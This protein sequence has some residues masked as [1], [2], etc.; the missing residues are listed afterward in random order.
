MLPAS[1]VEEADL[2]TSAFTMV[3]YQFI[4]Q[5]Y[6]FL[7]AI[8]LVYSNGRSKLVFGGSDVVL[9]RSD[10]SLNED[11]TALNRSTGPQGLCAALNLT[12]VVDIFARGKLAEMRLTDTRYTPHG[13]LPQM[14]DHILPLLNCS[15]SVCEGGRSIRLIWLPSSARPPEPSTKPFGE[16]NKVLVLVR[17]WKERWVRC[18]VDWLAIR[19]DGRLERVC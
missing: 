16:L 12:M 10:H 11:S 5:F 9:T 18:R 19:A 2:L 1:M 3:S 7:I 17:K 13:S 15:R 6:S 14:Y 4:T 8:L